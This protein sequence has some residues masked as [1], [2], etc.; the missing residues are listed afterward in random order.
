MHQMCT[1]KTVPW[2]IF[3]ALYGGEIEDLGRK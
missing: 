2:L 3:D 1:E